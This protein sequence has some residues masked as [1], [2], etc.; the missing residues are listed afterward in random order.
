MKVFF[1]KDPCTATKA[2]GTRMDIDNRDSRIPFIAIEKI[3]I[4]YGLQPGNFQLT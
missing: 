1:V 3:L 4:N 2:C